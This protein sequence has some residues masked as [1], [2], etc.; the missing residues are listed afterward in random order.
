[1]KRDY[2]FV[3]RRLTC[4][5]QKDKVNLSFS[6]GSMK[7]DWKYYLGLGLFISNFVAYG[8]IAI[9]P[10]CGFSGAT[11]AALAT[12]L[13]LFAEGA[14][15]VSVVLLGKPFLEA[16]KTWFKKILRRAV[17]SQPPRPVSRRRHYVGVILF[18]LSL[19]PYLVS[20]AFL[21]LGYTEAGALRWVIG[22]LLASDVLFI[23]S[24][25]VLG[26]DFW[27]RLK[28]LFEWPGA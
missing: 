8:M 10:F 3:C 1:M 16:V 5:S 20:E 23:V 27:A 18:F 22:C 4:G 17:A 6:E 12:G 13:V 11:T 2:A 7:H 28:K 21:I 24:L 26:A 9:L 25:F 14:F 19:L 15:L